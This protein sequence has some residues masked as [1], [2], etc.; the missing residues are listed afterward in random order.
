MPSALFLGKVWLRLYFSLSKIS[1]PR[2]YKEKIE[3]DGPAYL[4]HIYVIC[5]LN[6]FLVEELDHHYNEKQTNKRIT[7]MDRT[8]PIHD[9]I[10]FFNKL[11]SL[12][13]DSTSPESKELE[14]SDFDEHFPFTMLIMRC[15]LIVALLTHYPENYSDEKTLSH[16]KIQYPEFFS[17]LYLAISKDQADAKK[18]MTDLHIGMRILS[19]TLIESEIPPPIG[20]VM[21]YRKCSQ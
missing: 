13:F 11:S 2:Y 12:R 17:D 20:E 1:D 8:N 10:P 9:A 15:P 5:L 4:M 6:A 16:G 21:H 18:L 19:G 14:L 7:T 3:K